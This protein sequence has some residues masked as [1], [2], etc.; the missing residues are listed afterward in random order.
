MTGYSGKPLFSKLGLKPG[1]VCAP[2]DPPPHYEAL[3]EGAEGVCFDGAAPEA[4]VVHLFVPSRAALRDQLRAALGRVGPKGMLWV[5]WPKK[6]SPLFRDLT[7]D[8]LRE[9]IL[10][11]GWVD[12]KVCAVDADWSGLKFT[13]R[14][15]APSPRKR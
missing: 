5:S 7:E 6:S 14:K 11:T 4:D 12:V 3:V 9:L 13:R 2:I 15:A 1:M 10:P 8:G